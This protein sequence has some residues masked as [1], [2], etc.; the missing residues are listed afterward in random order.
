MRA[1]LCRIEARVCG[2]DY[3]PCGR[4]ACRTGGGTTACCTGG[5]G[6][7]A[8]GAAF[9]GP[10]SRRARNTTIAIIATRASVKTGQRRRMMPLTG[11]AAGSGVRSS[12]ARP[13]PSGSH[14]PDARGCPSARRAGPAPER[15]LAQRRSKLRRGFLCGFAG[16]HF[17]YGCTELPQVRRLAR[18]RPR[19][20]SVHTQ[21]GN[22]ADEQDVG[23]RHRAVAQTA[24]VQRFEGGG[25]RRN[26]GSSPGPTANARRDRISATSSSGSSRAA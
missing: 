15:H 24:A 10:V 9:D 4:R 18:P 8:T 17:R 12:V 21:L 6:R 11:G 26:D 22:I 20:E 3:C 7:G 1:L 13:W 14:L 25:R 5:T 16:Q 19:G 23:R 2:C